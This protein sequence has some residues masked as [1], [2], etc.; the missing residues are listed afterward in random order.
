V[1]N[2]ANWSGFEFLFVGA[3]IIECLI[4]IGF[5]RKELAV[6]RNHIDL[7]E[8]DPK[9]Y[10]ADLRAYDTRLNR[11]ITILGVSTVIL[12]IVLLIIFIFLL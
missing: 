6:L 2:P 11:K 12:S 7:R 5:S 9:N 3:G 4:E 10:D 1:L 8:L